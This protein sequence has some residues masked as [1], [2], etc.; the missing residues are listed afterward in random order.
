MPRHP[1]RKM[2][3][4]K[5]DNQRRLVGIC[6]EMFGEYWLNPAAKALAVD[7]RQVARWAQGEYEPP[8]EIVEQ[9]GAMARRKAVKL[10]K[11]ANG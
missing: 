2:T 10:M 11:V 1:P 3:E 7:Y 9:I 8:D 4:F 6:E 5:S